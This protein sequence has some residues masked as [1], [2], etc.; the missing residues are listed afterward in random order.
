MEAL[1]P[2]ASHQVS[3]YRIRRSGDTRGNGSAQH[4][5]QCGEDT[6]AAPPRHG[7]SHPS[8]TV[9]GYWITSSARADT[10]GGMVRPRPLAVFRLH[11]RFDLHNRDSSGGSRKSRPHDVI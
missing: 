11:A 3:Y 6:T 4:G 10:E 9:L 2:H 8:C 1:D 5:E 7:H